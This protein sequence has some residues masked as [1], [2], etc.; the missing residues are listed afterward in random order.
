MSPIDPRELGHGLTPTGEFEDG[1]RCVKCNYDLSGLP[2]GTLCPECGTP[3]ARTS[4]D[5]KRGT[6]VSRAPIAYTNKL[7]T[8][9]WAAAFALIATW[10][11]GTIAG[12]MPHPVTFG[13]RFA[14]GL[15]WL[16]T[17]WMATHPKPDRFEPGV[18]DA[19]DDRRMRLATVS[20]QG[21]WLLAIA[22]DFLAALSIPSLANAEGVLTTSAN[23][24]ATLAAGGFIPLGI[25]LASLA[26]W[27]GDAEA[28]ARCRTASWL[29]AFYGIGLLLSPV[30]IALA[31][32]F[33]I[34]VLVFW[35]A[36][37]VGVIMLAMSLFG[38]A[39]EAN[40]AVQN[41]RHKSVVSGRRAVIERDRAAAAESKL[42]ERLDAI[43][44]PNASTR[45]GRQSIPKDIPVPKSHNI[46]RNEDTNPYAIGDD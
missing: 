17:L 35:L 31:P 19:F 42:E 9:L 39:R 20:I 15:A 5:K 23:I 46:E 41:A 28:E 1:F 14:A 36:Y 2:K 6:G 43:D 16:G 27:M 18:K 34:L 4:Y 3:N 8:W 45:A 13:I 38:L 11:T 44:N 10:F 25:M 37:L 40:W 26:N 21:L 32:I 33:F 7:G 22:L 24:V 30:I 29:V 12:V